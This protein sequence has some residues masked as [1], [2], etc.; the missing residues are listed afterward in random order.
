MNRH[1]IWMAP[2]VVAVIIG[3]QY[4]AGTAAALR[5]ELERQALVNAVDDLWLQAVNLGKNRRRYPI[6]YFSDSLGDALAMTVCAR[7]NPEI[8][9]NEPLIRQYRWYMHNLTVPHEMGHVLV[10]LEDGPKP[11]D[12]HGQEWADA[13]RVLVAHDE[14]EDIIAEQAKVDPPNEEEQQ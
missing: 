1:V 2:L 11:L 8:T 10:C 9:F 14:A 5:A 6:I 12:P 7:P 3:I 4:Y 13:V